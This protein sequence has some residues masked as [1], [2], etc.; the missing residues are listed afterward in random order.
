MDCKQGVQTLVTK[1]TK[2]ILIY[3][4]GNNA[5]DKN[6]LEETLEQVVKNLKGFC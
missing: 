4:Q 5:C 6:Y 1:D 2:K 3:L